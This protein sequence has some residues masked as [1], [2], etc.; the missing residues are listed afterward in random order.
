MSI[1]FTITDQLPSGKN[2]VKMTRKGH[3]YPDERFTAWRTKA[4]HELQS[5]CDGFPQPIRHKLALIVDYT[6]GDRRTRDVAGM[7]D[8]I[9]HLLER[10]GLIENDGL[11]RDCTW[12]EFEMDRKKPQAVV[13]LRRLEAEP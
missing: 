5:Q 11:I 4:L 1:T 6:P 2:A 9:C 13:T 10:S 12:H 7:L 8:A 3:R